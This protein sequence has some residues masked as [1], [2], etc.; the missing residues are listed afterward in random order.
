LDIEILRNIGDNRSKSGNDPEQV[1]QGIDCPLLLMHGYPA[2]GGIL[3]D[4]YLAAIFPNK[5]NFTRVKIEG[6]GHNISKEHADLSLPV[7][8]PWLENLQK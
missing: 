4:E 5:P 1:L 8:L 6:A 7:V 3:P 2:F